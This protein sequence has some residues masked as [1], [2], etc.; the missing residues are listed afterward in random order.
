MS[1]RLIAELSCSDCGGTLKYVYCPTYS[2]SGAAIVIAARLHA[3]DT[4]HWVLRGYQ[5][6][7]PDC[8]KN[9]GPKDPTTSIVT[10]RSDDLAE[11]EKW[12]AQRSQDLCDTCAREAVR[13]DAHDLYHWVAHDV[14][15]LEA[16]CPTCAENTANTTEANQ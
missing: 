3:R 7:C 12:R 16:R 8:A 15:D 14:G 13:P 6:T 11:W 5:S 2:I 4:H 10:T 9:S 1:A